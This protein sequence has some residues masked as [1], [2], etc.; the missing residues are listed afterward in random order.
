V[1]TEQQTGLLAALVVVVLIIK[2]LE[3][4]A[5]QTKATLA[6]MVQA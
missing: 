3:V 4:Q 6:G 5:L 1:L 2:P